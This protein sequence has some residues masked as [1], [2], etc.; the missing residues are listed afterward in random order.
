MLGK[1]ITQRVVRHSLLRVMDAPSLE[2]L[3]SRLNGALDSP[4]WWG[5]LCPQQEVGV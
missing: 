4:I 1:K 3:K 2:V 5:Q